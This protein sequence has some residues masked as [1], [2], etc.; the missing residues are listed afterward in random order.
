MNIIGLV[1]MGFIGLY[2]LVFLGSIACLYIYDYFM[3][4]YMR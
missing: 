3:D 2:I 4:G 1:L